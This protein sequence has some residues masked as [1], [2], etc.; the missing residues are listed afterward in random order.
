MVGSKGLGSPT[1]LLMQKEYK[2]RQELQTTYH[3]VIT[4]I[5]KEADDYFM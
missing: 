2:F 1:I 3:G 4:L 5:L